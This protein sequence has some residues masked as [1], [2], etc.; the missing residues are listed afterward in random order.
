MDATA[1]LVLLGVVVAYLVLAWLIS[2]MLRG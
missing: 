1:W 2:R